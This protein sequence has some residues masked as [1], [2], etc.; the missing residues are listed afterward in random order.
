MA[1]VL[2]DRVRETTTVT[3]T[4]TA[5]L[6]GAGTGFNAFSEIGDGN[7]TYYCIQHQSAG[8]WEV[9]IGTY[10]A[11]GTTLARTTVLASSN[12]GSAVSFSVGT[13]D[14]FITIPAEKIVVAG[15]NF[16]GTL[17][18]NVSD[19]TNDIDIAAG[20]RWD[21]TY[22]SRV[23]LAAM[24]KRLDANWSAGT[25]NGMRYSGAAIANTTYHIFAVWKANGIDQDY[26]AYPTTATPA[27]VLAALQAETGGADYVY[28]VRIGSI[29]RTGGVIKPFVQTGNRFQWKTQVA[30]A[31]AAA[32][33]VVTTRTLT[34]PVGVKTVALFVVFGYADVAAITYVSDP[35]VDTSAAG[36]PYATLYNTAAN[37]AAAQAQVTTNTSAQ[38]SSNSNGTNALLAIF[39]T[40]W[41]DYQLGV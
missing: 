21:S 8:E 12:G 34:L 25:G 30:D 38:V 17:S 7:T 36:S 9:G 26:Y 19:A 15:P 29:V 28:L 14:V 33:T 20:A 31:T 39:T 13:K 2:K 11:S 10:T 1:L 37:Y 4:G 6:L 32:N 3:G 41:I 24:T 40:G 23:T 22:V 5:T 16:G 27:T 18:N 35:D